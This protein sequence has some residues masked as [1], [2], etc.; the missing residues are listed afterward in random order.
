MKK[1]LHIEKNLIVVLLLLVFLGGGFFVSSMHIRA[2]TRKNGLDTLTAAAEQLAS[3][4]RDDAAGDYGQMVMLADILSQYEELDSREVRNVICSFRQQNII[5]S[6][7]LLLPDGEMLFCDGS[8]Y[9]LDEACFAEEAEKIPYISDRID[10]FSAE[11]K[12]VFQAVPVMQGD[13]VGGI[14]YGFADLS[15]FNEK[16]Q[17]SF[18]QKSVEYIILDG[19]SGDVIA[20]TWHDGLGNLYASDME[21]RLTKSG[22]TF[23]EMRTDIRNGVGGTVIFLSRTLE[24]EYLYAAYQPVGVNNWSVMVFVPEHVVM[25]MTDQIQQVFYIIGIA[26]LLLFLGCLLWVFVNVR[27]KSRER[28]REL[29]KTLYMMEVQRILLGNHTDSV[30]LEKALEKCAEKLEAGRTFL[31]T[32]EESRTRDI[33]VWPTE[34][35]LQLTRMADLAAELPTVSATLQEKRNLLIGDISQAEGLSAAEQKTLEEWKIRNLMLVPV[36]DNH[37]EL[38]AVL[39]AVNFERRVGDAELL[40]CVTPNFL[41]GLFNYE[42]YQIIN[43]MGSID[44]LTGLQNRNCYQKDIRSLAEEA[45]A[46]LCCI[47]MDANGLHELNNYLGHAAGD[48]MLCAVGAALQKYFGKGSCYR[49][50]GDEF[51]VFCRNLPEELIQEKLAL[52]QQDMEKDRYH[53]STGYAWKDTS[54]HI[55]TLISEAE[56]RMYEDKRK[57]YE[58]K[59]DISKA[60]EMNQKLEQI[61]LEKK[62]F[63]NFLSLISHYFLG[64]Y[65]VNLDT[66]HTRVIYKPSY[67]DKILRKH[68]EKFLVSIREYIHRFVKP[69]DQEELTAFINYDKIRECL[70]RGEIAYTLYEKKDGMRLRLRVFASA[71]FG[72]KNETFWLFEEVSVRRE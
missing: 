29:R 69:S 71:E 5:S 66:D 65:V 15:V 46:S 27:K 57:Y 45:H 7:G 20:D 19:S 30:F 61:L 16:Y 26:D 37:N 11:E 68:E 39:G 35:R 1:S 60:R 13:R 40:E 34:G 58:R 25:G 48:K 38:K 3:N 10:F 14:L 72:D 28:E 12:S 50:G 64:V 52:F 49:I 43:E 32:L 33:Y 63:E 44:M 21:T 54:L 17:L 36:L 51:V 70:S 4:V 55:D 42:S 56:Q 23:E 22:K 47:Y 9:E 31:L 18:F 6:L 41:M 24:T 67:F 62:D 59:G 8:V 2:I 53:I